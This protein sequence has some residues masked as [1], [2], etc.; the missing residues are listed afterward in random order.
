MKHTGSLRSAILAAAV[1]TGSVNAWATDNFQAVL[2]RF[3]VSDTTGTSKR[4]CLCV[5]GPFDGSM[6][7]VLA[8]LSGN[9]IVYKYECGI[10]TFD[11]GGNEAGGAGCLTNGGSSIVV[12]PK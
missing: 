7:L 10:L 5:G 12:L 8:S 4:L 6:G 1:L 9:P 2:K 11:Q 3:G